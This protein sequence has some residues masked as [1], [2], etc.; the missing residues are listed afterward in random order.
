MKR[1][2]PE[3]VQA[4]VSAVLG[5]ALADGTIQPEERI[6]LRA[7]LEQFD[8]EEGDLIDAAESHPLPVV[9]DRGSLGSLEKMALMRYAVLAAQADGS[10]SR[11][12]LGFLKELGSRLGLNR[13]DWEALEEFSAELYEACRGPVQADRVKELLAKHLG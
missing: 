8:L 6:V 1:K 2:V 3:L 9:P 13:E 4:I 5:T 12:E 7:V 10:I 11:K